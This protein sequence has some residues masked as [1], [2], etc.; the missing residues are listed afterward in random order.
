MA[1]TTDVPYFDDLRPDKEQDDQEHATAPA[2]TTSHPVPEV[3]ALVLDTGAGKVG[4]YQGAANGGWLLRPPGGGSWW[5][6]DPAK[7]EPAGVSE[8]LRARAAEAN[9][10]SRRH[11]GLVTRAQ[12]T[13]QPWLMVKGKTARRGGACR[14]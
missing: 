6:A 7:V 8:Q 2:D 11:G 9:A 1:T 4:E 3:G 10:Q 12:V 14:R 5:H 13:E